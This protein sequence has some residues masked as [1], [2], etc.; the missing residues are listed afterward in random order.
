MHVSLSQ[1]H[2]MLEGDATR[3]MGADQGAEVHG[4]IGILSG[5]LLRN[6]KGSTFFLRFIYV[7]KGV[8]E[9]GR[10][11]KGEREKPKLTPC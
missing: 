2:M 9:P 7:L 6:H 8:R 10:G 3:S 4:H 11:A 1:G 5:D